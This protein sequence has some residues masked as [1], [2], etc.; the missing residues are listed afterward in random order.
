TTPRASTVRASTCVPRRPAREH[1]GTGG[2]A[3]WRRGRASS[4][5]A[6]ARPTLC[7]RLPITP[8]DVLSGVALAPTVAPVQAQEHTRMIERIDAGNRMSEASIHGG[9]AYLAGQVPI[10]AGA[11]IETQ[12]REVL[13]EIDD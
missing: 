4:V 6:L 3:L 11:D 13:S 1:A 10:T 5:L 9:V 2:S 8:S 7:R 12:T